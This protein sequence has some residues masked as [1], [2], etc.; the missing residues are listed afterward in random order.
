MQSSYSKQEISDQCR[1][2]GPQLIGLPDDM[3]GT[4]LLWAMSGNESSFGADCAPRHEPAYDVG[5]TY[6][7]KAVMAPLLAK[8][9]SAAACS[10]GPW[11]LMFCNAPD[12]WSPDNLN[13]LNLAGRATV[14]FL[15]R[16]I[17]QFHPQNLAEIGECWNGGHPMVTPIAGVAAYVHKL[18]A[19]YAV[20][21]FPDS[22]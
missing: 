8:W 21:I 19:N 11:Q 6:G 18:T 10:Y 13:S 14:I 12:G 7:S 5:G 16:Q 20:P 1:V 3:D 2:S 15:N 22:Q 4:Q 9:G 17:A